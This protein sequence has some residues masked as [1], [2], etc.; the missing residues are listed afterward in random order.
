MD[1]E[2][3]QDLHV[4]M[5]QEETENFCTCEKALNHAGFG[6]FNVIMLGCCTLM[7]SNV[8]INLL[9][10]AV[11]LPMIQCEM[12][13]NQFQSTLAASIL[14]LGYFF[15]N[16][17]FGPLSDHYGRKKAILLGTIGS[18]VVS[19]Q[20]SFAPSYYWILFFQFM[21][22]TFTAGIVIHVSFC[23][24]FMPLHKRSY[25]GFVFLGIPIGFTWYGLILLCLLHLK[26]NWRVVLCIV[27][28]LMFAATASIFYALVPESPRF[29]LTAGKTKEALAVFQ[30]I[31]KVNQVKPKKGKLAP[32][33]NV[34]GHGNLFESFKKPYLKSTVLLGWLF[35]VNGLTRYGA[36]FL[37]PELKRS[38]L[39]YS[40]TIPVSSMCH[41]LTRDDVRKLIFTCLLD[42][43]GILVGVPC[44]NLLGRKKTLSLIHILLAASLVPLYFCEISSYSWLTLTL[45]RT[46]TSITDCTLEVY[47]PEVY[48]TYLRN[49]G[50]SMVQVGERL[51]TILAAYVAQLLFEANF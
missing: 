18:C 23:V 37:V 47:A 26:D 10:P 11:L 36:I 45:V 46:M 19:L 51:Y 40:T 29:L 9:S 24:E 39:D 6:P 16:M 12:S 3:D 48:P 13:L 42:F 32:L 14:Y 28:V 50:V 43:P 4:Q 35:F 34:T 41:A 5:E 7:N 30:T 20:F 33:G 38:C 44:I 27:H 8:M 2:N 1:A 15:G 17:I 49:A 25:S 22:G 31:W 21:L